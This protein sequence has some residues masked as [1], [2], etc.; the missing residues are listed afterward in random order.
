MVSASFPSVLSLC[1]ITFNFSFQRRKKKGEKKRKKISY[2][3]PI[4][5]NASTGRRL[6]HSSSGESKPSRELARLPGQRTRLLQNL[7]GRQRNLC[8]VFASD[9]FCGIRSP[10]MGTSEQPW[11]KRGRKK[12]GGRRQALLSIH[13][14][15]RVWPSRGQ[16]N[17]PALSAPHY[18]TD[19]LCSPARSRQER[20]G[21]L[22]DWWRSALAWTALVGSR[23]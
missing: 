23:L 12:G 2:I 19:I 11:K 15:R 13:H 6:A 10:V 1:G 18:G 22:D 20:D 9:L 16:S 14:P 17:S 8:I 21:Y 4:N 5:D 7:A 3:Y